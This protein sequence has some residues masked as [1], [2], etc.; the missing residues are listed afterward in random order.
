[1]EKRTHLWQDVEYLKNSI[2]N[3]DRKARRLLSPVELK[4]IIERLI[5]G[6]ASEQD[7]QYLAEAFSLSQ[8][9]L[10]SGEQAV[11]IGG[12]A[13]QAIVITGS[14]NIIYKGNEGTLIQQAIAPYLNPD[15]IHYY[16]K[17][18]T[19]AIEWLHYLPENTAEDIDNALKTILKM[20]RVVVAAYFGS[21]DD[22]QIN[23]NIMVAVP[24]NRNDFDSY[25][26]LV[27]MDAR[28][29]FYAYKCLL[30]LTQWAVGDQNPRT[31]FAV[32][33]HRD[34]T[35][36]LF[37]APK[38]YLTGETQIIGNTKDEAELSVLSSNQPSEIS[39]QIRRY[40][41]EQTDFCSFASWRLM[42]QEEPVGVLNVQSNR[43][44][45]FEDGSLYR[46]DIIGYIEPFC[47]LL[48]MIVHAANVLNV[49]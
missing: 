44:D 48:G 43:V 1:M 49:R 34:R 46:R 26:G 18:L 12:D 39:E 13:N 15:F 17:T 11:A 9:V 23:A 47:A 28:K 19:D 6:N 41:L 31:N 29:H 37:G 42:Y 33:V 36:V 14:N 21:K 40:F 3:S 45:T 27:F 20:I 2:A 35:Q 22:L 25:P 10:A 4:T 30:I 16:T 5:A 7:K 24:L 32:P 8:I 38:T